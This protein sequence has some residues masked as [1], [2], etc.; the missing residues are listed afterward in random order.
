MP[1]A[2]GPV[3]DAAEPILAERAPPEPAGPDGWPV[4]S[5]DGRLM[6]APNAS[7]WVAWARTA[8]GKLESVQALDGWLAAMEPHFVSLAEFDAEAV[9]QVKGHAGDRRVDLMMARDAEP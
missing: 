3:I 6:S 8:V 2:R 7:R 1:P 9:H 5:P 4:L